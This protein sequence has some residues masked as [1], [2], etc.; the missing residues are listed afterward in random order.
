MTECAHKSKAIL[1][2]YPAMDGSVTLPKATQAT[3]S[4]GDKEFIYHAG[5]CFIYNVSTMALEGRSMQRKRER[6]TGG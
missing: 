5:K 4:N 2:L 1:K 3:R 6:P